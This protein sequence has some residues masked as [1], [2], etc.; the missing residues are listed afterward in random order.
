[1]LRTASLVLLVVSSAACSPFPPE[2]ELQ[3]PTCDARGWNPT[4]SLRA[5]IGADYVAR[6]V[7]DREVFELFE[8]GARCEGA[9]DPAACEIEVA[10]ALEE[11]TLVVRIADDVLAP[12]TLEDL[13]MLLAP[14][15]DIDEALMVAVWSGYS[16][17]VCG[18]LDRTGGRPVDGEWELVVMRDLDCVLNVGPMEHA[19]RYFRH[20]VRVSATGTLVEHAREESHRRPCYDHCQCFG[21]WTD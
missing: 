15:D 20:L 3:G 11:H 1:M 5:S 8:S 18:R 19:D 14:I 21:D 17:P 13:A 16:P 6:R 7:G 12:S 10:A 2:S 4:D 9:S